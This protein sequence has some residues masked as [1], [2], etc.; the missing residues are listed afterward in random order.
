MASRPDSD[1]APVGIRI[2]PLFASAI[3]FG[4]V[5][6]V[7][8]VVA[9]LLAIALPFGNFDALGHGVW[10]RL[11]ATH[12]PTFHFAGFGAVS[13]ERPLFY[14]LQGEMW[15]VFGFHQWLGR[16][17][18]YCFSLVLLGSIAYVATRFVR[19]ERRFAAACAALVLVIVAPFEQYI[20]AGMTDIPVA[21]MTAATAAA[22]FGA[23]PLGR[24]RLGFVASAAALSVLAKP[25]AFGALA[26]LG[27]AL[28]VGH[29]TELRDRVPAVG[30]LCFGTAVG[31]LYDASQ[32][33]YL[34]MSLRSFVT[35][36]VSD[37]P[38]YQGLANALRLKT[39]SD[40]NWLGPDLRL[41]LAFALI[42]ASLR[43][44]VGHRWSVALALVLGW[45]R[46]L[47]GPH[48][49]HSPGVF[50]AGTAT[51]RVA[52]VALSLMLLFSLAAPVEAIPE[53]LTLVRVLLWAAPAFASWARFAVYDT[54]LLAP[55]W[56]PLVILL[57]LALTPAF[58]GAK[59][60]G[61]IVVLVPA[62]AL[63]VLGCYAMYGINGLRPL[64][65]V[66]ASGQWGVGYY[67]F[68][69]LAEG[70]S[71]RRLRRRTRHCRRADSARRSPHLRRSAPALLLRRSGSRRAARQVRRPRR[72]TDLRPDRGRRVESRLPTQG[73]LA[74]LLAVLQASPVDGG[75]HAAG[76]I[77]RV[78]DRPTTT[79]TRRLRRATDHRSPT[80]VRAD[81]LDGRASTQTPREGAEGGVHWVTCRSTRLRPLSSRPSRT[82]EQIRRTPGHRRS[83][84]REPRSAPD[85]FVAA[86]IE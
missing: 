63:A 34:H 4:L 69:P 75:G 28:L 71:R 10:S 1:A 54:R 50:Q 9:L 30:A 21:A 38:Y 59:A 35:S 42:Y 67:G 49:S 12:W 80:P 85:R 45:T 13:Y 64:G 55:V 17:L 46:S 8:L 31:L 5:T 33:S 74:V 66:R 22:L 16:L 78:L 24:K 73:D 6:F 25:S 20:A 81:I 40:P 57:V 14:V 47:I 70:R 84:E 11:I 53:R 15:A 23:Q 43:L 82:P 37:A 48:F 19:F 26:G 27:L 36:G 51:E 76:R 72:A 18:S 68:R 29:R 52:V 61:S 3:A 62:A 65:L 60:L 77:R 58:A 41:V 39:L 44:V 83:A 2:D 32:A 7:V 86:E 56:A 79:A